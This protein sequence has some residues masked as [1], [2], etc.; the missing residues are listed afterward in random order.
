MPPYVPYHDR[1][2]FYTSL[3][4]PPYPRDPPTPRYASPDLDPTIPI[5][6]SSESEQDNY[7]DHRVA[8]RNGGSSSYAPR[9]RED[10]S[11]P[12]KKRARP[13]EYQE[14]YAQQY[15]PPQP[16]YVRLTGSIFNISPRNPFT[17]VV[18]DFIMASA[19]GLENVE[20]EI[21]L[22][23][24]TLPDH[25]G[26]SRRIRLPTQSEMIVPPDY[27]LG[28]FQATM[29]P[30]QH[31]T[32]NNLLNQ[33]A[34]SSV[35]LSPEQGRVHFSRS[36]LTDSFHGAGGRNGKVRVS[37][38]RETGEVVEVVKKRRVA[39]LNVYCPGAAFDW[40]I[41]VNVE[42]PYEMPE[43]PPNMTRDK[44]RASYRHQVCQVDLTHVMSRENPQ[45]R[46][47]SSFE[48]EIEVRDVP[49]LLAEGAAGSDR[50]DEIL[51][52]VL[53]TARMLIKNC[54]PAPQ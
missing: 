36:K 1:P 7:E 43:T 45:S 10:D 4:T 49:S 52:N 39:D 9:V 34:Q 54:D 15:A 8:S 24:L 48:L 23:I 18:G 28:P 20:I 25:Q 31:K 38:S 37:R 51:Q 30:Q 6:M 21:K 2:P 29:H 3:P 5:N 35:N 14:D 16:E 46:P 22:G 13:E 50:F 53:D 27:P 41:S 12:S 33:A 44:D 32:L 42:E 19:T 40:R 11:G 47:V 26:P 17:S